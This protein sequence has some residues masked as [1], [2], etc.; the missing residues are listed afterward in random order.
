ME[1]QRM[2][3]E[4]FQAEE[5]AF[6]RAA[7]LRVLAASV[8]GGL[9][10]LERE[11]KG[12]PAGL[13]TFSLVCI[14]AALAMVT[15]EYIARISGGNE[16]LARMAAQVISGIGF[17]GAG[18]IIVTGTNQIRGLTTAAALWVTAALGI[19]I[20]AGFY[21]GA[22]GSIGIILLSSMVCR[23]IDQL[24]A[25]KSRIL[26]LYVEGVNEEFMLVLIDYLESSGIRIRNVT[27]R[28]ENK[29][30]KKDTC[31]M[32]ELDLGCRRCH[33]EVI[34]SIRQLKGLRYVEEI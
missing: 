29:W 17:L 27:R 28:S 1:I 33:R 10:G 22:F 25:G 9:I 20:G 26:K 16:D 23:M 3:M 15:N 21:T 5:I 24:V 31:V 11:L 32:A 18:T 2:L 6:L 8:C 7:L 4:V 13:K 14:G 34:D 19:C 12:R 30:Y